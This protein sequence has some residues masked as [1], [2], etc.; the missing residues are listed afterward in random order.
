VPQ[1]NH[2]LNHTMDLA[3]RRRDRT[4]RPACGS[5]RSRSRLPIELTVR[6]LGIVSAP[7]AVVSDLLDAGKLSRVLPKWSSPLEVLYL[8]FPSRR[9]QS[10][11]LRAFIAFLKATPIFPPPVELA[12]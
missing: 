10:A 9:H 5:D 11:A 3:I 12:P 1:S 4:D 2:R 8:Y 6:G 7:T